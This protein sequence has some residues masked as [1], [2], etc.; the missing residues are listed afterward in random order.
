[1]PVYP[2]S[3]ASTD[4]E[5][6][7][8]QLDQETFLMEPY[9]QIDDMVVYSLFASKHHLEGYHALK[10]SSFCNN[11]GYEIGEDVEKL[12]LESSSP[13]CN[14]RMHGVEEEM[15]VSLLKLEP[16]FTMQHSLTI[17]CIFNRYVPKDICSKLKQLEMLSK[18][19][20]SRSLIFWGVDHQILE[21][22]VGP[23]LI[24]HL[25]LDFL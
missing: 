9:G 10:P 21:Q 12:E 8:S 11:G 16:P 25:K 18:K 13:L 24:F 5:R 1:M 4:L 20:Y 15:V 17:S 23:T 6:M 19:L 7:V 2:D 3:V 22:Y 14:S